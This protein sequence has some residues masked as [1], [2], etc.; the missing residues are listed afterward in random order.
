[1][2]YI[3]WNTEI[4]ARVL[5]GSI[6]N[7]V[8]FG[9]SEKRPAPPYVV[10]KP[11]TGSNGRKLIQFYIHAQQ[12]Q[13]NL[14]EEYALKELPALFKKPLLAEADGEVYSNKLIDTKNFLSSLALS[15]DNTISVER[16]FWLPLLATR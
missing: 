9:T 8:F 3:T 13:Q 14:I 2:M 15:D 11:T 5:E 10:I 16:D 12:G 6:K 4:Y 7:V 1:M